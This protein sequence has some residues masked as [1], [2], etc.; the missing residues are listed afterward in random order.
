MPA[1]R[2]LHSKSIRLLSAV[3]AAI[4]VVLIV[5]TIAEG[6]GVLSVGV[7]LGVLFLAAGIGRIMLLRGRGR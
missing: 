1:P 6:G 4:G 3:M 7:L 5:R 2:E